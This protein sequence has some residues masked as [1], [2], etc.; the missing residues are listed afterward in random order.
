MSPESLTSI[1]QA[2][3]RASS[4]TGE[5]ERYHPSLMEHRPAAPASTTGAVTP[6]RTTRWLSWL[7]GAAVLGAVVGGALHFSEG[8]AFLRLAD[9][10]Q[11]WWLGI[12]AALQAGTYLSQ[13]W[14]WRIVGAAADCGLSRKAALELAFAKL[15]ADQA[16]PSAG[17]SS[18]VLIAKALE[19]RHLPP[20]T[21]NASVLVNIASYHLAYVI[22][23]SAALVMLR[24]R[25]DTNA[26]VI[27]TAALFLVFSLGLSVLVLA[28]SGP[29]HS[30]HPGPLRRVRALRTMFEFIAGADVRLVRS[31]GLL[32]RAVGLQLAIVL[33]DAATVWTLIQALGSTASASGVFASFMVASLF[34]TMGVVP[35]GLGTFEASS[36][37]MLR[38]VGVDV[39]VALSATLLFRGLSFW[40]PMLP[41]YWCSRR[42]LAARAPAVS[43]V[44]TPETPTKKA[45][46]RP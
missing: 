22:A 42:V 40:L 4:T 39:A 8:Q 3:D 1:R 34:R 33:L 20:P 29:R 32:A 14:I 24:Q 18:S 23:L 9:R 37:L 15:F 28:L 26:L 27:V 36:V 10:A 16:L 30:L 7:F 44:V 35:G 41:G 2:V 13:G 31:S 5:A 38:M 12:A 25:G 17:L 21:V 19:Q 11:P 45:L 43:G 46:S 6:S